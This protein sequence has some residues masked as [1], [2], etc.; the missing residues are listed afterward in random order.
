[1]LPEQRCD[2]GGNEQAIAFGETSIPVPHDWQL[3]ECDYGQLNGMTRRE[4]WE[5]RLN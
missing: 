4:G 1:V 2:D 5:Y 3:R